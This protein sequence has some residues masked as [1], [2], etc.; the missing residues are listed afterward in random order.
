MCKKRGFVHTNLVIPLRFADRWD[1][2]FL[3]FNTSIIALAGAVDN[4]KKRVST[5]LFFTCAKR[6]KRPFNVLFSPYRHT[7]ALL[8][9]VPSIVCSTLHT[10]G[11]AGSLLACGQLRGFAPAPQSAD[12]PGC[13]PDTLLRWPCP[14]HPCARP[15]GLADPPDVSHPS[16]A[17]V[18][19]IR[20]LQ[21]GHG[22]ALP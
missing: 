19:R 6:P 7:R 21:Q 3:P 18:C 22:Y 10:L 13:A 4:K 17:S 1:I 14:L 11:P 16:A 8:Q 9:Q 20:S 15:A 2:L 5:R 12:G